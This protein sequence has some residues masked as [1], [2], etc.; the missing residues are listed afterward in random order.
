MSPSISLSLSISLSPSVSL[1]LS[2]THLILSIDLLALRK[3]NQNT[4]LKVTHCSLCL[5]LVRCLFLKIF[6]LS[7]N[8]TTC[9]DYSK[10]LVHPFL[11]H[12]SERVFLLHLVL[13]FHLELRSRQEA[14]PSFSCEEE[15]M[16]AIWKHGT[17]PLALY[18]S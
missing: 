1:S 4:F 17:A 5:S 14:V 7:T 9:N 10:Q 13:M 11:T 8:S 15:T 16:Q 12:F 6:W 18:L 3:T 2:Y